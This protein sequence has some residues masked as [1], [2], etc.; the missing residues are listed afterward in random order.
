MNSIF[1]NDYAHTHTH[2]FPHIHTHTH[3]HT[4]TNP[5]PLSLSLSLSSTER[6]VAH[7]GVVLVEG[8]ELWLDLHRVV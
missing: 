2:T 7:L 5:P 6:S 8:I 3:T 1:T 4:H